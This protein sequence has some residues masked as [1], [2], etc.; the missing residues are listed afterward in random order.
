MR[1]ENGNASHASCDEWLYMSMEHGGSRVKSVKNVY[2][3]T[4]IRVAGYMVYQKNR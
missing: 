3:G 2:E 4:K 1:E